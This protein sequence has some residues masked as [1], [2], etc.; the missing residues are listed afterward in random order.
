MFLWC[1]LLTLDTICACRVASVS[2]GFLV[3]S[4][5]EYRRV[6]FTYL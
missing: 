1:L 3:V 6:K 2:F 5:M 4:E